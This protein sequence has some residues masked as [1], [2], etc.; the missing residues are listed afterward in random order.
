MQRSPVIAGATRG[1][2]R[3]TSSISSL[4]FVALLAVAF[5]AGALW[6]GTVLFNLLS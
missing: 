4:A 2:I 1:P 6:I 5:W 3:A